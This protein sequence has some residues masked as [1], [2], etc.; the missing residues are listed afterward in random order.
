MPPSASGTP[1]RRSK[2]P[3]TAPAPAT[4]RSH[5]SASS[6]PPATQGPATAA[7]VGFETLIRQIPSQPSAVSSRSKATRSAPA[8]NTPLAPVRIPTRASGSASKSFQARYK[9]SAVARSMALRRSGRSMV[10]TA[11]G[12]VRS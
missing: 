4:L 12:P 8:Q 9:P 3:N 5:H 7:M 10:I 2:Q 11:T 6:R 1:K